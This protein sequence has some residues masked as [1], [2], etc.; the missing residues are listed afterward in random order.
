MCVLKTHDGILT[1]VCTLLRLSSVCGFPPR[2]ERGCCRLR[3][4]ALKQPLC[5]LFLK[6]MFLSLSLWKISKAWLWRFCFFKLRLM[7]WHENMRAAHIF[8]FRH[9]WFGSHIK[10]VKLSL[11][12]F[13]VARCDRSVTGPARQ[14]KLISS[15]NRGGR[16]NGRKLLQD[17]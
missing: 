14:T 8:M 7:S 12:H 3:T 6:Q 16:M 11:T 5:L 2:S 10:N 15:E 13:W 1:E 17:S 4:S 9:Y